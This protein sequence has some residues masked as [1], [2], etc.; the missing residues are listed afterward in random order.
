MFDDDDNLY[1]EGYLVGD[2]NS[3]DGFMPLDNYGSPDSGCTYIKYK[4]EKGE[5]VIL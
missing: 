3:H 4:N 5:W 1:F 2:K